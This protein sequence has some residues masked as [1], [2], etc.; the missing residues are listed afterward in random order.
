MHPRPGDQLRAEARQG[1]GLEARERRAPGVGAQRHGRQHPLRAARDAPRRG[2]GGL[3]RGGAKRGQVKSH[4]PA[5]QKVRR[6]RAGGRRAPRVA[7]PGHHPGRGQAP[8]FTSQRVRRLR[9]PGAAPA[10]P[11][12]R[13]AHKRGSPRGSP[14][15]AFSSQ[16]LPSR[17]WKLH[18]HRWAGAHRR[19]GQPPAHAVPHRLGVARRSH[20]LHGEGRG[21]QG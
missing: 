18:P 4:Q 15:Q 10:L 8:R 19:R 2:P 6:A 21:W 9:H 14:A 17:D 7:P 13:P 5:L 3:G 11:G 1:P 16:D 12:V 20:A